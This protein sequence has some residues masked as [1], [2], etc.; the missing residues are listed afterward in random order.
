MTLEPTAADW[1][2]AARE[3]KRMRMLPSTEELLV[4]ADGFGIET[5][6]PAQRAA[7]R[8]IDGR[9]LGELAEHPKALDLVGGFEALKQIPTGKPPREVLFLA[10][11]RCAKTIVACAA[12]LRMALSVDV[13]GLGPGEVPRV[14]LVSLTLDASGV[15]YRQLL[16]MLHVS[17][18]FCGLLLSETTDML[19]LRHPSGKPVEI[20]SVAGSKAGG[21]LVARWSAGCVFDEAPR[22]S[23]AADAVINLD[24]ARSAI[25]GRLL[26]GSQVLYVGSPWAPHGPVYEMVQEHWQRPSE[27]LVV[28]RGTGP[29][30][31]PEWWTE[32]R[33]QALHDSDPTAYT[34]DVLGEF[35]T[36]ESGLLNPLS[37]QSSTR[38]APLE[39]P[40]PP[41]FGTANDPVYTVA[42]DPSEGAAKGNGFAMALIQHP[43]DLDEGTIRVVLTKE[44][45]GL[46]P[47]ACW[48]EIAATLAPYRVAHVH[49]DQY[50]ASANVDLA[51]RY[52]LG[53][54]VHTT[55][56]VSKRE[57]W[58]NLATLLHTGRLDLPPEPML[59]RD[60]LSVKKK[61]TQSS[62]TV[63]LPQ[64]ADGRHCDM[65]AA[66]CAAV[67][68][69]N[70]HGYDADF[71][72]AYGDD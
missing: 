69:M 65:A 45:R 11:I 9:P 56:S 50:A 12:A 59:R 29:M 32:E 24:D 70:D 53:V 14:S 4:G 21:S 22:M 41:R 16:E 72:A 34:T 35:A 28:L 39:L 68:R 8:V 51:S 31:N 43:D 19:T 2:K 42:V 61:T 5:A 18:R 52:G 37:V 64:T 13:S 66:L 48:R 25:L 17:Q 15:A 33:C 7:C 58:T 3:F 71:A 60:L 23:G 57:D 26:P 6:T 36:P 27:R 44:W 62:T 20:R 40:P 1:A 63:V 46:S 49:T 10:A 38:E 47:D 30:L 55:T 67:A 54:E